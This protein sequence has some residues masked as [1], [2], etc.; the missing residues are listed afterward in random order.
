MRARAS[1]YAESL[2]AFLHLACL[3]ERIYSYD[4]RSSAESNLSGSEAP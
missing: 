2:Q 1:H 3:I 4:A